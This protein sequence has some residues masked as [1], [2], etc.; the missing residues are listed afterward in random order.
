MRNFD[1]EHLSFHRT[2]G[3]QIFG[4]H[5]LDAAG[6]RSSGIHDGVGR[7]ESSVAHHA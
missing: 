5:S 6:P 4:R 2:N 1:R 3:R 7:G